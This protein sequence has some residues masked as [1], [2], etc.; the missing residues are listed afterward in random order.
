MEI[1]AA[2]MPGTQSLCPTVDFEHVD[3]S[4]RPFELG[5]TGAPGRSARPRSIGHSLDRRM[6]PRQPH[7]PMDTMLAPL[8]NLGRR[9]GTTNDCEV[10]INYRPRSLGEMCVFA[11]IGF[12]R[13]WV[14]SFVILLRRDFHFLGD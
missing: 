5:D 8:N 3:G 4:G 9:L 6:H 2:A 13:R 12:R 14:M 1:L 11:D 7:R 10:D